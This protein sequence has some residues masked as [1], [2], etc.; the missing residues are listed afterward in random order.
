MRWKG[1]CENIA[2]I[3]LRWFDNY[4]W[5]WSG[6]WIYL[7][8]RITCL[9]CAVARVVVLIA[10]IG[11]VMRTVTACIRSCLERSCMENV[12]YIV[13]KLVFLCTGS[14]TTWLGRSFWGRQSQRQNRVVSN[15]FINW[16][17]AIEI[18]AK[19]ELSSRCWQTSSKN[20]LSRIEESLGDVDRWR[21][22]WMY[23]SL[24]PVGVELKFV[25]WM[26]VSQS[27]RW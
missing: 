10:T 6:R 7:G 13:D 2:G 1:D 21:L 14:I 17:C 16:K 4:L 12:E 8:R 5:Y 20:C 27:C 9:N 18:I 25:I 11:I 19:C 22:R 26:G 3:Q 23:Y 15:S 24:R